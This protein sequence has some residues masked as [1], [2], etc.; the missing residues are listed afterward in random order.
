[1]IGSLSHRVTE[2]LR[3]RGMKRWFYE[4]VADGGRT[5]GLLPNPPPFAEVL[6]EEGT[7]SVLAREP[8]QRAPSSVATSGHGGGSGWRPLLPI[9]RR[10]QR[11]SASRRPC[12]ELLVF[13]CLLS[14][15]AC[16]GDGGA[17]PSPPPAPISTFAYVMNE[18]EAAPGQ[19]QGPFR[20]ALWIRQGDRDPVKVTELT[21]P[22]KMPRDLC[23]K[24]GQARAAGASVLVGAFQRLRVTPDGSTVVFEVTD[25]FSLV[26]RG[27][28]R[29]DQEGFF[30]VRAD[31]SGLHRLADPSR[32]A[33]FA[34]DWNC[35]VFGGADCAITV[36]AGVD[37]SPDG[38][39]LVFTDRGPDTSGTPAAQIFTLDL[40]TGMRTQLTFLP[41]LLQCPQGSIDPDAECV[42]VG[43]LP[44]QFPRF[45]DARTVAFH[46][47]ERASNIL[48][49][50]VDIQT[51]KLTPV[52]VVAIPGGGLVP[53]F[54]ITGA[55][56]GFTVWLPDLVPVNG[57]GPEGNIVTEA[58]AFDAK[59]IL[60][61]T[62]FGRSDT[63]HTRTTLDGS[64]VLFDA[65]DD[66]LGTNPVHACELFSIDPQGGNLRQLTHF[67]A[68]MPNG[69]NCDS[70][71]C[72]GIPCAPPVCSNGGNIDVDR[73]TASIVFASS[74]DPFG[75]NPYGEQAFAMRPD[76][77]G[78]RQLTAARGLRESADGSL[79]VELAAPWAIAAQYR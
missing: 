25:D 30:T 32:A 53:V 46:R 38:R 26:F 12:V 62:N 6:T 4:A 73:G 48:P 37:I 51:R 50:T 15:A 36:W 59:N 8:Q 69:C 7:G 63:R 31:G 55:P 66:P 20:Q 47:R 11:A 2:S 71:S 49:Y 45:L 34:A 54:Q 68:D 33:N 3:Q 72:G 61:L 17:P 10:L 9:V 75:T 1:M 16:G 28:V 35:I 74:C 65:S 39:Q 77:T 57:P 67:G 76:G 27:S 29:Q 19:A 21:L 52:Q 44:I 58:F 78:L 42:P 64:R 22:S 5:R 43:R 23:L 70:C 79:A 60:Q 56:I 41:P 40:A 18:C 24:Y 14:L 13:L